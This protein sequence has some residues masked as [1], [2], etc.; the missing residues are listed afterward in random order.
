MSAQDLIREGKP[1][2]ALAAVQDEVRKAAADAKPRVFLFQL[3][4]VLGNWDRALTQL[5]VAA[6]LDKE[7]E[8][9]AKVCREAIQCQALRNAVFKGA[10]SP[11]IFGEP[12]EWIGQM[13]QAATLTAQGHAKAGADLRAKA[14]EAAPA[15]AGAIEIEDRSGPKPTNKEEDFEWVADADSR[16]GPML[17]AIVNARYY[18]IPMHRV[19]LVTIEAPSDLRDM[20]W[21]PANF[22]WSNG[23]TAVGMLFTR[24]PGSES[25]KDGLVQLARKTDWSEDEA[26]ASIG[27]GQRLLMTDAGDYPILSVRSL[28][29]GGPLTN[30]EQQTIAMDRMARSGGIPGLGGGPPGNVSFS[31]G[32]TARPPGEPP[33]GPTEPTGAGDAGGDADGG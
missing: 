33:D 5:N 32:L 16:L 8:L 30:E 10:K 15:V 7:C 27:L 6:D 28:R 17:E 24:Y 31:G 19:R 21:L 23:G 3:L 14:L 20:V 29:L 1:A 18:W 9:M 13:V 25:S 22:M 2:E 12:E 11:L 4:S 26:G